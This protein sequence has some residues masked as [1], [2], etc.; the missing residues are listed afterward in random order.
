MF[1]VQQQKAQ[2]LR[3]FLRF[4][5]LFRLGGYSRINY[6]LADG[7]KVK[8]IVFGVDA[9][10]LPTLEIPLLEGRN[11]SEDHPS[12]REQAVLVNEA[13]V[14]QLN[15]ED[16]VGETLSGF[17]GR[18]KPV[19]IRCYARFSHRVIIQTC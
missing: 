9:D 12:D 13:L 18:K 14:K 15:I 2:Y 1:L 11:F 4:H 19:I 17:K 16:P 7:K 6:Q 3:R 10:Y 8:I 5:E